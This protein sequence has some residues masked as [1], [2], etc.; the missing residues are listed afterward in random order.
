MGCSTGD[1]RLLSL[2]RDDP[3]HL[4]IAFNQSWPVIRFCVGLS[5]SGN[6]G[7]LAVSCV[8]R[9]HRTIPPVEACAP[10]D[11]QAAGEGEA[12]PNTVLPDARQVFIVLSQITVTIVISE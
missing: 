11:F 6:R 9:M 2:Q 3:R 12:C 4:K 1:R 5:A 8:S 7:A 10:T